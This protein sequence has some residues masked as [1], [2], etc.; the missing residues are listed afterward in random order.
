MKIMMNI[1]AVS[2]KIKYLGEPK[3]MNIKNLT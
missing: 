1:A 3:A 2:F